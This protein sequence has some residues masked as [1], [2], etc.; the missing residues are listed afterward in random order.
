M[1]LITGGSAC[2]KSFYAENLAV[3]AAGDGPHIY[4]AAMKPYG[5]EGE[6]RIERHRTARSGRGF[7]TVEAYTDIDMAVRFMGHDKAEGSVV[8]LECLPNLLANEMFDENFHMLGTEGVYSKVLDEVLSV[9][10]AV[11]EF[12]VVTNEIADD[13]SDYVFETEEYIRVL[14]K[15]NRELAMHAEKVIEVVYSVPVFLKGGK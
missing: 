15:L 2:G 13:G 8:L 5:I 10:E 12:I 14:S 3:S 1:I 7:E 11:R 4:M 6:R 9:S